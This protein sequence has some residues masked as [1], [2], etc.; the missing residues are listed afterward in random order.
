[1]EIF[2]FT[3]SKS[4][5]ILV[6]AVVVWLASQLLSNTFVTA[7]SSGTP[8]G[9]RLRT[10]GSLARTATSAVITLV[11]AFMIIRE[12]GFDIAPLIASAGIAGLAI[13][14][15][16]QTLVKDVIAGAF[17]LIENQFDEGDEIEINGK[18][19]VVEKISLRIVSLRD[20]DSA[21]HIVPNGS[22]LMVSNFSKK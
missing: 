10:L 19:G 4:L 14:F 22:I 13:G 17:I 9:K 18:R 2:G 8:T 11:A 15:G 16:A 3:F 20:K 1:M 5:V 21:L 12:L 6:V 7:L